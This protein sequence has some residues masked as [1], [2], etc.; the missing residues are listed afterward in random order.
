MEEARKLGS[1]EA[2]QSAVAEPRSRT[3]R[4]AA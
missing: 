3:M 4:K 1:V 2:F